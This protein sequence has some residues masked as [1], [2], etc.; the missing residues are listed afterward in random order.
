MEI[1]TLLIAFIVGVVMGLTGAGGSIL[2]VPVFAYLLKLDVLTA[3]T[4]SLFVV[5][6]TSLVGATK[7]MVSRNIDIK[8]ALY[9][10]VPSLIMVVVTRAII[11]PLIPDLLLSDSG[12]QVTRQNFLLGL[13]AVMIVYAG[14]SMLRKRDSEMV[15]EQNNKRLFTQG[16]ILGVVM[17]L[18]GAGGGFM[19]V[20]VLVLFAGMEMKKAIGTSLLIISINALSGF[21]A[22]FLTIQHIDWVLLIKF[23]LLMIAGILTG[24]YFTPKIDTVTLKKGFGYF[25]LLVALYMIL[26]EFIL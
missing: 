21:F 10:A 26:K 11:V 7:N 6:T 12:F 23:S 16:A 20:P 5:G 15:V 18:L 22:G 1:I 2:T 3:T 13:F 25:I 4:Y 19:I 24:G 14:I 8:P 9:F 17:G